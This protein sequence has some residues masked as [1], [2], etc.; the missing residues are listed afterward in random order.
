MAILSSDLKLFASQRYVDES[1]GGGRMSAVLVQDGVGNN[2]FPN[3]AE[4]DHVAGRVQMRKVYAA[5]LSANDD[6]LLTAGIDLTTLPADGNV[7]VVAFAWGDHTTTRADAAAALARFPYVKDPAAGGT[8][9]SGTG[10]FNPVPS[11]GARIVIGLLNTVTTI[12]GGTPVTTEVETEFGGAILPRGVFTVDSVGP[13]VLSPVPSWGSTA[14]NRW[15]GILAN[16]QAPRCVAVAL[17]T[18]T[19]GTNSVE[20]DRLDARAIP[21]VTPYPAAPNG[22][23][24]EGLRYAY[25]KVPIFRP[26]DKVILRNGAT[27]ELALI[28]SIDYRGT[29]TF[30]SALVNSFPSGSKICAIVD[31]GDMQASVGIVFEQQ[32]WTRIFSDTLIGGA[33]DAAYDVTSFPIAVQN[34][35]AETERWAIVFTSSTAFKLIGESF[36]QI[37]TG[38]TATDFAPLNP[39]T[40]QPYFTI[41]KDGWG[42]GWGIGNVLRFNTLGARKPFWLARCVSP[43]AANGADGVTVDLRGSV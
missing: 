16:P 42:S 39:I 8:Y 5:V 35:G 2:V 25:G 34:I 7:D 1:Y 29:I 32:A 41:D 20:V 40:N 23:A 28:Q 10:V 6:T 17:L 31:L 36:G 22:L 9:D 19:S 30:Q 14:V 4:A 33:P 27:V 43:G 37:A 24:S 21:N 15:A 13:V 18:A 3:I 26:G 38:S 12:V 11:A